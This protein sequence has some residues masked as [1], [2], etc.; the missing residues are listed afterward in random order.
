M[1]EL[2]IGKIM[3]LEKRLFDR[4]DQE[5][6]LKAPDFK[7]AFLVL[8]DTDLGQLLGKNKED[9]EMVFEED[10]FRMKKEFSRIIN[11]KEI[12]YFLFLRFDR[13]NLK[14]FLKKRIAKKNFS[15]L[16]CSIENW[17]KIEKEI[18]NL[19]LQKKEKISAKL[20]KIEINLWV[21]EMIKNSLFSLK[22]LEPRE[23]GTKV[24]KG[25]YLAKQKLTKLPF[26]KEWLK[27]EI[28]ISNLKNI[29]RGSG[30]FLP[31]GNFKKRELEKIVKGTQ[32]KLSKKIYLF[33]EIFS[34]TKIFQDFQTEKNLESLERELENFLSENIFQ[35]AKEKIS[36]ERILS[37]FQKKLNGQKNIRLILLAKRYNLSLEKIAKNL[38]LI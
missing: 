6:M 25:Y 30:I 3:V 13:E 8:Y 16:K 7:S 34:L 15:Y 28:D 14:I 35:K 20:K 32:I 36:G 9:L 12:F 37:F 31:G 18:E 23:I 22:K 4:L 17:Q 1:E 19:V 2:A 10:L 5:R 11:K 29:I 26:L 27:L 38:L 33:P 24:D 21:K